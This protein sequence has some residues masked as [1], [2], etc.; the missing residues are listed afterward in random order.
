[1]RTRSDLVWFGSRE[2]DSMGGACAAA[3]ATLVRAAGVDRTERIRA[4]RRHADFAYVPSG[5]A[6][7]NNTLEPSVKFQ[8]A[9]LSRTSMLTRAKASV[10]PLMPPP[11]DR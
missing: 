2:A 5:S 11:R 9:S 3:L 1:M 8:P 4:D 7:S 6:C 10:V